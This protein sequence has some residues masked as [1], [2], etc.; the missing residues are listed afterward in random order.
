[1]I[2]CFSELD[3]V[4]RYPS[5]NTTL[6][7]SHSEMLAWLGQNEVGTRVVSI[8]FLGASCVFEH[9]LPCG[10]ADIRLRVATYLIVS[11]RNSDMNWSSL[12]GT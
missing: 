6:I 9:L 1:M 8:K 2:A 5:E 12:P 3:L 7:P 10:R 4:E 11:M